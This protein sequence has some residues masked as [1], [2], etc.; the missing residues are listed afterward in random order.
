MTWR[1]KWIKR[2]T[3]IIFVYHRK[4]LSTETLEIRDYSITV[5]NS[6][7]IGFSREI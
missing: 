4:K 7:D 3:N 1:I 5:L 6:C 2:L